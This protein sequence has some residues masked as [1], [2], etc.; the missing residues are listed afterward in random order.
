M[1]TNDKNVTLKLE[2]LE[3]RAAPAVVTS[4][5]V[6][7]N[8]GYMQPLSYHSSNAQN[9]NYASHIP[10]QTN[11]PWN[12]NFSYYTHHGMFSNIVVR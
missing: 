5:G 1:K 12:V 8:G 6:W 4:G 7:L 3:E 2:N 9:N 10:V 11:I